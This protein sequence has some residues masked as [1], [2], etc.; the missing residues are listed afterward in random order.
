MLIETAK[1]KE[2]IATYEERKR[3]LI[4]D[5]TEERFRLKMEIQELRHTL[6]LAELINERFKNL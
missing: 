4:G 5:D 2:A 6:E 3:E 1:L